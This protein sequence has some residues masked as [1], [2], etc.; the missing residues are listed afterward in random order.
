MAGILKI[1]CFFVAI[2]SVPT[3]VLSLFKGDWLQLFFCILLLLVFFGL[4]GWVE[5]C[6]TENLAKNIA[7][8]GIKA[9]FFSHLNGQG[10]VIDLTNKKLLVGHLDRTLILEFANVTQIIY[11]DVVP[12]GKNFTAY[13][14]K[15]RTNNF[16][17]P[18]LSARF[19]RQD[20]RD[21]AYAKLHTALGF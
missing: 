16:N 21:E 5:A 20:Q 3:A 18:I 14:L 4:A 12:R 1:V 8:R 10:V 19:L 13:D 7:S 2:Y 11:E 6:S 15:V 9:D 17:A